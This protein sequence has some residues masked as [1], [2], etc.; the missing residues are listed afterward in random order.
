VFH[1]LIPVPTILDDIG[2]YFVSKL[3]NLTR[4]LTNFRLSGNVQIQAGK[5]N[6]L[7]TGGG[8]RESAGFHYTLKEGPCLLTEES[9]KSLQSTSWIEWIISFMQP[10]LL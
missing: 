8:P 7:R 9:Q 4:P 1:L 6:R 10:R 3:F 2:A 5:D